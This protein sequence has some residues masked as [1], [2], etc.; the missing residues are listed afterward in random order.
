MAGPLKTKSLL[1]QRLY[2][3]CR[4]RENTPPA[5]I[6]RVACDA[7]VRRIT[8]R[9]VNPPS[10]HPA[11]QHRKRL[12]Q[13]RRDLVARP[14]AS[15]ANHHHPNPSIH[16][17][18]AAPP[19]PTGHHPDSRLTALTR[20]RQPPALPAGLPAVFVLSNSGVSIGAKSNRNDPTLV[21]GVAA[22]RH[23]TRALAYADAT[24]DLLSSAASF[25]GWQ[26]KRG[27]NRPLPTWSVFP[28]FAF[29]HA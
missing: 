2:A 9:A 25:S 28:K 14:R 27:A 7:L 20:P 3:I 23:A 18:L 22:S 12:I 19:K 15:A 5:G 21:C 11:T 16:H 26:F 8:R 24:A 13:H 4:R 1:N 17:P 29:H 6:G 10:S